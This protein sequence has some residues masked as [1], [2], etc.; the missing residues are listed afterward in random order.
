VLTVLGSLRA[1]VACCPPM[2]RPGA[3]VVDSGLKNSP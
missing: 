3:L 1:I 2:V